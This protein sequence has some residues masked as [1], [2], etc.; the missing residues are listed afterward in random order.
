M[1]NLPTRSE[2]FAEVRH[3]RVLSDLCAKFASEWDTMVK[4][5]LYLH[6]APITEA[7]GRKPDTKA[8]YMARRAAEVARLNR[9][10]PEQA[11]ELSA[12]VQTYLGGSRDVKAAA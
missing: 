3:L 2:L 8:D 5:P 6:Y 12:R 10:S 7:R 1:T 4:D 11:D 9:W